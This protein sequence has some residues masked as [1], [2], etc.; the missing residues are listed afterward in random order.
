MPPPSVLHIHAHA[1][2]PPAKPQR[3]LPNAPR[4]GGRNVWRLGG[5]LIGRFRRRKLMTTRAPTTRGTPLHPPLKTARAD[6]PWRH[7][8]PNPCSPCAVWRQKHVCVAVSMIR[9][10]LTACA[11]RLVHRSNRWHLIAPSSTE[12][13][14]P[15][16]FTADQHDASQR[17][18]VLKRRRR[19]RMLQHGKTADALHAGRLQPMLESIMLSVSLP[20]STRHAAAVTY[21]LV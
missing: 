3:A 9:G 19:P 17:G 2:Q 1:G 5:H 14:D 13:L 4:C 11:P 7:T 6:R 21:G 10:P 18:V 15:H 20:S 12:T 16:S 8:L